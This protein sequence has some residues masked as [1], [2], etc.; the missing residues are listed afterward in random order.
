MRSKKKLFVMESKR[1]SVIALYFA[2][3]PQVA[4]V[5]ALQYLNVNKSF[6]SRTIARYRDTGSVARVQKVGKK[7]TTTPE[8]VRKV[9]A[10]FDRNPRSSGRPSK[11]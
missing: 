5:R 7:M 8:T 4:I 2:G 6:V 1:D 11:L 3:N 10:R 9:K